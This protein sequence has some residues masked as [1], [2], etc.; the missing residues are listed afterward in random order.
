M[1]LEKVFIIEGVLL[2][3][4]RIILQCKGYERENLVE[5]GTQCCVVWPN[6]KGL[7]EVLNP[8]FRVED[9]G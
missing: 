4:L 7:E 3:M 8:I 6:S 9:V 5:C 2:D 1:G